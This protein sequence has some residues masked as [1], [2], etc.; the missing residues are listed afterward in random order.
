MKRIT[1][2][3]QAIDHFFPNVYSAFEVILFPHRIR[4]VS[5]IKIRSALFNPLAMNAPHQVRK[6]EINLILI[7]K[8]VQSFLQDD[9]LI[10]ITPP[11]PNTSAYKSP[12]LQNQ[13]PFQVSF[14]HR[15][16]MFFQMKQGMHI[17]YYYI[18]IPMVECDCVV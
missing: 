15:E 7:V 13:P 10:P 9:K 12:V 1:G 17:R 2:S 18:L 6:H 16:P 3:S 5:V 4:T 8:S 14:S 11:P